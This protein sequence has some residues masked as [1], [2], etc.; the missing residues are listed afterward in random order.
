[1]EA[2]AFSVHRPL[3]CWVELAGPEA[4]GGKGCMI[5]AKTGETVGSAAVKET[6][7]FPRW[8]LWLLGIAGLLLALD[9]DL[10]WDEPAYLYIAA[11]VGDPEFLEGAFQPTG[12][13]NFYLPK[14]L[15]L[16]FVR[17]LVV[18]FGP[19]LATLGIVMAA[20]A[21]M[22]AAGMV[23]AY[24][25]LRRLLPHTRHLGTATVLVSLSPIV[26]YLAFKTLPEAPAMLFSSLALYGLVRNLGPRFSAGWLAVTAISLTGLA[27]TRYSVVLLL[28]GFTLAALVF[29][30]GGLPRSRIVWRSTVSALV[31]I[32]ATLAF[33]GFLGI[34]IERYLMATNLFVKEQQFLFLLVSTSTEF[35]VLWLLFPA[36]FI[37][38]R[39]DGFGFLLS[40]FLIATLPILLLFS[41][42]ESRYLIQN[43]VPFVGLCAL[44]LDQLSKTEAW[45]T[46]AG[47]RVG[48]LAVVAG[49]AV[50]L[51]SSWLALRLSP[52]EVN[53]WHMGRLVDKVQQA[54]DAGRQKW[55]TAYSYTDFHYLSFAY[56]ELQVINVTRTWVDM[57]PGSVEYQREVEHYRGGF[58]PSMKELEKIEGELIFV[59]FGEN[60]MVANARRGLDFLPFIDSERLLPRGRFFDH[61]ATSW[62]WGHPGIDFAPLAAS[63]PYR[64]YTVTLNVAKEEELFH[65]PHRVRDM[66]ASASSLVANG[67]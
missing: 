27:L 49:L 59:G 3:S 1:M 38:L 62:M 57:P 53:V 7:G 20:Y 34:G 15:H 60:F 29:P 42:V 28:V 67:G 44:A 6:S 65:Q 55:L 50:V 54:G 4:T 64:A 9:G 22:V 48:A 37:A 56:P 5:S 25:S 2:S 40:W 8:S 23:L 45:R 66:P 61:F 12:I 11:F 17:F 39:R 51:V 26:L 47:R 31:G 35:G 32:A 63:G 13:E 58:A 16:Y 19:G 43:I 52:A 30:P 36:A 18:L 41:H 33:L 21:A 46:M 14:I 10:H 24:A